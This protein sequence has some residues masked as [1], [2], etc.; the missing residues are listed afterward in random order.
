[1]GGPNSVWGK[2][3]HWGLQDY[4]AASSPQPRQTVICHPRHH[5][6]RR[7]MTTPKPEASTVDIVRGFRECSLSPGARVDNI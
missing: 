7:R 6:R 5:P 4:S 3:A 2:M 1:M